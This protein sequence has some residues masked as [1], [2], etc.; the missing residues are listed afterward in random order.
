MD[1]A[2]TCLIRF[3]VG[4]NLDVDALALALHGD[5]DPLHQLADNGL[6]VLRRRGGG[7]PKGGD[8]AG[9]AA[10][11]RAFP[12]RQGGWLPGQQF[13]VLGLQAF[14]LGQCAFPLP[15]QG[16]RHQPV[17]GVHGMALAEGPVNLVAGPRQ[18]QRPVAVQLLALG[19]QVLRHVQADFQGGR[20][21]CLEDPFANLP[22]QRGSGK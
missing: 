7:M 5:D 13:R 14:L 1:C 18:A 2:S 12:L 19:L 20:L 21:Q 4:V 3:G 8:A 16:P 9:Q 11:F 10:D 6:P 15:L 22:V 17:L